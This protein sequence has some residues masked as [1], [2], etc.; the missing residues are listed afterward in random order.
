MV[1]YRGMALFCLEPAVALRGWK[2]GHGTQE[3]S[4]SGRLLVALPQHA[5]AVLLETLLAWH[6]DGIPTLNPYPSPPLQSAELNGRL[7]GLLIWVE[8][9]DERAGET[10]IGR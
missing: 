9:V 2:R 6:H 8:R 5:V 7:V 1:A 10:P 4:S 3:S